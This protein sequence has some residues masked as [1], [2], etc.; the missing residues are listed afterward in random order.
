MKKSHPSSKR[1][2]GGV[3]ALEFVLVAP[4]LIALIFSI[5][6]FGIFFAKKVDVESEARNQVRILALDPT[7]TPAS[8]PLPPG[9]TLDTSKS[10]AGCVVGNTTSDARVNLKSNYTFSIPFISLGTKTIRAEGLM[11]CGG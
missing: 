10:N 9:I 11:R 2:D 1:D 5:A 6:Q 8:L 3:V 4:F 7:K